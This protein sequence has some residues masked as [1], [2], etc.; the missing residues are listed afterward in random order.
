MSSC[1]RLPNGNT[2]ICSSLQSRVFEVTPAGQ[3]VWQATSGVV[4]NAT[5]VERALWASA[6]EV[7]AANGGTVAFDLIPGTSHAG[8]NYVL[9]GS[10]SGTSPGFSFGGADIPLNLDPYLFSAAGTSLLPDSIGVIGANGRATAAFALPPGLADHL[11]GTRLHHA[12]LVLDTSTLAVTR[13][14]NP[15]PLLLR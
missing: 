9:A 13:V 14:S 12:F 8:R 4:F 2:L 11:A 15:E 5:Y 6:T 3:K 7:S 10:M 1:E